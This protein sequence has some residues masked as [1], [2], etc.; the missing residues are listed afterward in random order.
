LE[1]AVALDCKVT[2]MR[3]SMAVSQK[4]MDDLDGLEKSLGR[5][6]QDE[7]QED[8]EQYLRSVAA[9]YPHLKLNLK[10]IVMHESPAESIL[11]Y[12]LRHGV[13]LIAM[14]THGRTG[15]QRLRY[16]SVTDKVLHGAKDCSMLVVRPASARQKGNGSGHAP[17]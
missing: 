8:A 2:L 6:L 7:L 5:R 12:A 9:R 10:T 1:I 14:S 13:D 17:I 16:G 15:L 4:D 11:D 3:A